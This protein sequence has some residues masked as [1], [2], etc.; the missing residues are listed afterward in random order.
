MFFFSVIYDDE[1]TAAFIAALQKIFST[2]PKTLYLALEK[3]YVFT[4]EHLDSVAPC[5][6]TFLTLLNKV[7][8]NHKW[9]IQQLPIDFPK[10]FQ[11]DRVDQL[12]LWKITVE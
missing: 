5:Y 7:N 12:V 11:Y 6:E 4:T 10:Y 9:K 3:R 8:D 1:V 2:K